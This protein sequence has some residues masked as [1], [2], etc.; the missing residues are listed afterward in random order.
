MIRRFEDILERVRENNPGADDNASGV[1]GIMELARMI[2]RTPLPGLH[3]IAFCLE[4]PPVFRT[5]HMGSFVYARSLK[6]KKAL[7]RGM[8][9]LDMIGYFT[10]RP[11]SQSFPL[12]FMVQKKL[13]YTYMVTFCS[14]IRWIINLRA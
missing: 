11:N 2:S 1:A 3:L 13:I 14:V 7:V 6:E 8:I 4:E 10:D 9:C 12:F 5:R